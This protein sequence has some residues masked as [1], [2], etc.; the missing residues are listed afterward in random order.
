MKKKNSFA[1]IKAEQARMTESRKAKGRTSEA[2]AGADPELSK[3]SL[4]ELP[5]A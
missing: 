1:E 3:F 5:S 2:W 4:L